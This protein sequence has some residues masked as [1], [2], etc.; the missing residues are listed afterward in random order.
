AV[1]DPDRLFFSASYR[2]NLR[3]MLRIRFAQPCSSSGVA[4]DKTGK[5]IRMTSL[6]DGRELFE[7]Q[8]LL[9]ITATPERMDGEDVFALFD[10][11]VP[12]ELRL[13]DAIVNRLVVPF[14]Y[15]VFAA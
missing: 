2:S 14:H 3:I 11:N 12:Y 10:H 15:Y 7:P 1:R 5:E 13:R 9:G 8:F 4:Q 6:A